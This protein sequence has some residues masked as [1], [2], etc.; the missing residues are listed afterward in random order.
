M[1]GKF[2]GI[3]KLWD[4]LT[5][6]AVSVP[7]PYTLKRAHNL[8]CTKYKMNAVIDMMSVMLPASMSE[9]IKNNDMVKLVSNPK[10]CQL[11]AF[12]NDFRFVSC[13]DTY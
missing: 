4:A 9:P 6:G 11:I 13:I 8:S 2:S 7:K 3:Y 1:G 5:F 12:N 10:A